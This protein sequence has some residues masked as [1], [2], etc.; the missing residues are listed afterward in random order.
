MSE[1]NYYTEMVEKQMNNH[2]MFNDSWGGYEQTITWDDRVFLED[3]MS[4]VEKRPHVLD[5]VVKYATAGV[6]EANRKERIR[7][8]Q[9]EMVARDAVIERFG[10]GRY[11]SIAT[12]IRAM[13]KYCYLNG[14]QEIL[15]KLES[16]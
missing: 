1:D 13:L 3:I 6:L 10:K 11:K 2:S 16:K 9:W 5:E 15:T 4:Y 8:T 14:W 12:H 7:S